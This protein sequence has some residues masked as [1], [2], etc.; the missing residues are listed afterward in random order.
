MSAPRSPLIPRAQAFASPSNHARTQRVRA[1]RRELVRLE[2]R[3]GELMTQRVDIE[4]ELA[5]ILRTQ[6][7]RGELTRNVGARAISKDESL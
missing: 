3:I 7:A 4:E 2:R 5:G 6:D 1:L